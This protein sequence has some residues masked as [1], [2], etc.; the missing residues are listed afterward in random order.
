LAKLSI[1]PS[2]VCGYER[3][4]FTHMGVAVAVRSGIAD[5]GLGIR[6]AAAALGLDF[7]PVASEDY[8]LVLLEDFA[9]GPLGRLLLDAIR[10]AEFAQ[11]VT[12][13]AGY[14]TSRSGSIKTL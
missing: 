7:V 4:E 9:A 5:A 1:R 11:A 13:L 8:D 3:E 2:D 10:S 14:D 12:T 6:Q